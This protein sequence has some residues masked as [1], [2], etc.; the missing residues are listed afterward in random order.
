MRCD[1]SYELLWCE[2]T[3]LYTKIQGQVS[4]EDHTT[5]TRP[6]RQRSLPAHLQNSVLTADTIGS[7]SHAGLSSTLSTSEQFKVELYYSTIDHILSEMDK[8]FHTQNLS[9]MNAIDTLHPK[10]RQFLQLEPLLPL[11]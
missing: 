3:A 5:N 1:N 6:T 4:N 11:Y 2:V 8:R 7:R 10:S 9:L